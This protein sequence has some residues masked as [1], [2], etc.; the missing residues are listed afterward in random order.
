M[1][2]AGF[3]PGLRQLIA[4]TVSV[5]RS[6]VPCQWAAGRLY[7]GFVLAFHNLTPERFRELI[8]AL[9][10]NEPVPLSLIVDRVK[11]GK[12][13]NG[14]FAI[15]VDDG[16][17][18]TVRT[19]A[20]VAIRTHWPVTFFLPTGYLDNPGGMPFQWL[21]NLEPRLL[22]RRLE[23]AGETVDLSNPLSCERFEERMNRVRDAGPPEEY[24]RCIQ[25]LVEGAVRNGWISRDEIAPPEPISWEEVTA[26]SA[27]PEIRFESHGVTHT[28]VSALSRDQL[29]TELRVSRHRISLHTNQSCRHFCY[30]FGGPRSIGDDSPRV[31][32]RYYDSAVTMSR[33]RL[34]GRNLCLLPRIPLYAEDT[35]ALVRL[36][37]LTP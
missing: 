9:R 15:T 29:E 27:H 2:L 20:A 13:T 18:D 4:Q 24:V 10:P 21:R 23:I 17:G 28:A 33:G 5:S 3:Q 36:K 32:A 22:N 12:S 19:I 1:T 30:P 16:V 7:G 6:Y 25:A 34:R 26:L 35:A 14:L 37:V 31:V 8:C 11:A